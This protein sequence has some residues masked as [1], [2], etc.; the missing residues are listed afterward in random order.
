MKIAWI[1]IL[2]SFVLGIVLGVSFDKFNDCHCAG[3]CI[4]S[5]KDEDKQWRFKHKSVKHTLERFNKELNLT[6][7]QKIQV[8]KIVREKHKKTLAMRQEIRPKFQAL[9]KSTN[10]ELKTILNPDQQKKL[11]ALDTKMEAKHKKWD[12]LSEDE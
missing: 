5:F 8:E 9:R 6:A 1:Q 2:F 10:E 12:K 4:K 3:G 7:E 11:D